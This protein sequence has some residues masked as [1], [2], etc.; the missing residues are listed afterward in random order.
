DWQLDDPA[1][2]TLET[3]RRVRDEVKANVEQL[4]Q[5]M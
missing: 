4:L 3:F 5:S 2:T 1:G